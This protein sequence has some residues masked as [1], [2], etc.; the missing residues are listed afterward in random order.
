MKNYYK[1]YFEFIGFAAIAALASVYIA[2]FGFGILPCKMCYYQRWVYI[3][4]LA[5]CMFALHPKFPKEWG[6]KIIIALLFVSMCVSITHLGVENGW[7]QLDLSCTGNLHSK[8][9][10]IEEF[11]AMIMAKDD[12]PCDVVSFSFLGLTLAGWNFIYSSLLF[13]LSLAL[14]FVFMGTPRYEKNKK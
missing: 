12:I 5:V 8:T 9:D 1:L 4:I 13:M 11:K 6:V 10:D 14:G 3:A 7:V 2:E